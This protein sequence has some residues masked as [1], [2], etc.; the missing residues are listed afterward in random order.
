M[1]GATFGVGS[2]LE[3]NAILR[4]VSRPGGEDPPACV[5]QL[6]TRY[7]SANL[8]ATQADSGAQGY[9]EIHRLEP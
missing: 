4:E 5:A 8:V 9:V 3:A 7:G 1:H 2:W 6:P